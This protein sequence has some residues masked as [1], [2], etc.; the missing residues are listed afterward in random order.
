[1]RRKNDMKEKVDIYTSYENIIW[2]THKIKQKWNICSN[3]VAFEVKHDAKI[4][5]SYHDEFRI[6]TE[7]NTFAHLTEWRKKMISN[8]T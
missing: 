4:L 3:K 8:Q 2:V 7:Q 6:F 5:F 1:M